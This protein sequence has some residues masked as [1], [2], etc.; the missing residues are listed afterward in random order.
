MSNTKKILI[1]IM[2]LKK[3]LNNSKCLL[4]KINTNVTTI[5][6]AIYIILDTFENLSGNNFHN[7]SIYVASCYEFI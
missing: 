3:K 2:S 6:I 5:I 7:V 4:S 1:V